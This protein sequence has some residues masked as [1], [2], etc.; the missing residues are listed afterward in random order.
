[1][2]TGTVVDLWEAKKS[3]SGKVVI[4][5]RM[6]DMHLR[7]KDVKMNQSLFSRVTKV[8]LRSSVFSYLEK[9]INIMLCSARQ[10]L[11]A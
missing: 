8:H 1:M 7:K 2:K 6:I 4:H 10:V 5:S 9:L 3:E 11:T